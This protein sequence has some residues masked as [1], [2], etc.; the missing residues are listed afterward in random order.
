MKLFIFQEKT[1]NDDA[2]SRLDYLLQQ[3]GLFS[4]FVAQGSPVKKE[5]RGRK[6]KNKE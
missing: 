1:E 4:H 2:K 6:P 3:A 5:N